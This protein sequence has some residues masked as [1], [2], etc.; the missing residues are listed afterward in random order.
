M[1]IKQS[2]FGENI[3]RPSRVTIEEFRTS[4]LPRFAD[5]RRKAERIDK[6]LQKL[7]DN[8]RAREETNLERQRA[9]H[10]KIVGE[11]R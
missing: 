11:E 6:G 4:K 7:L 3:M 1:R 2:T 9:A 5:L 8:E 10:R